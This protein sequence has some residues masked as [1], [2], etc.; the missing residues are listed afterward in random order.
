MCISAGA[1]NSRGRDPSAGR[2]EEKKGREEAR[3]EVGC[4][5]EGRAR[6]EGPDILSY[7]CQAGPWELQP[8][9][10]EDQGGW[11]GH[12]VHLVSQPHSGQMRCSC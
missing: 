2:E 6:G 10:S 11:A 5:D 9:E 3:P 1:K 12:L 7:T 8:E 4:Q